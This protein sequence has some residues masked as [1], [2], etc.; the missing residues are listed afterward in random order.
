MGMSYLNHM[1]DS[2]ESLLK[3]ADEALYRGKNGGRN[4]VEVSEN[5]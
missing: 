5:I 1:G 2:A 3:R 4:R